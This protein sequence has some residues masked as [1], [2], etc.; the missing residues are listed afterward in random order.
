MR[1]RAARKN[2]VWS[3]DVVFDQLENGR[4]LKTL[5]IVDNF[6]REC[7]HIEVAHNITGQRIVEILKD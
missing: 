1:L 7:L 5:P 6:T 4:V 3:Y 2:H